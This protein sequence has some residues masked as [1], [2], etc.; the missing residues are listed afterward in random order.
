VDFGVIAKWQVASA[1][2]AGARHLSK[3]VPCQDVT[4]WKAFSWGVVL[5][6]ADG[7][8]S[9]GAPELGARAATDGVLVW[10]ET[11]PADALSEDIGA[12]IL[13]AARDA[14]H[15]RA[16]DA[17]RPPEELASTLLVAV[18]RSDGKA[19]LVQLGDG[20]IVIRTAG[21]WSLALPPGRGE[22][23]NE[24]FFVTSENAHGRLTAR[25]A[26][27]VDAAALCSDGLEHLVVDARTSLPHAPFFDRVVLPLSVADAE[28]YGRFL[29]DVIGSDQAQQLSDD[30]KSIVAAVIP[31]NHGAAG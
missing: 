8:G 5:A 30:D 27:D 25:L 29:E 24:T 6:L 15:I 10:A 13:G 26:Q 21:V 1:A 17:G 19:L 4:A 20:A 9:A 2:V 23:A 12:D 14:V 7:A 18:L 16:H 3:N 28:A 31:E 11:A 22:Y